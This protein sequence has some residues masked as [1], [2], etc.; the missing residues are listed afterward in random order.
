MTIRTLLENQAEGVAAP[1][2]ENEEPPKEPTNLRPLP[3]DT[4]VQPSDDPAL[5]PAVAA[6]LLKLFGYEPRDTPAGERTPQRPPA[7]GK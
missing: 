2:P 1:P 5:V 7:H 4:T 3:V 6:N